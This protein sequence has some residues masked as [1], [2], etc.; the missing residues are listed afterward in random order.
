MN[1]LKMNNKSRIFNDTNSYLNKQLVAENLSE[2]V[3]Y[4]I[5]QGQE[6]APIP[7]FKI[8]TY[9]ILTDHLGSTTVITNASGGV[10]DNITYSPYGL[11][12]DKAN[13]EKRLYTGQQFD[14]LIGEYYY[15]ARYYDPETDRFV[16]P[17]TIFQDIY[18]PQNLNRYSYVL[19]NPYKL[20][21]KS[22]HVVVHFS[23]FGND[24]R[25]MQS[26][27]A[28][29][30][31]DQ[32]SA[33][34]NANEVEEASRYIIDK[35]TKDPNQPIII[36]GHS[37]GGK[38]AVDL[39]QDL[40]DMNLEVDYLFVIDKRSGRS[41]SKP[42]NVKELINI[43][44]DK[45]FL[46]GFSIE[47]QDELIEIDATHTNIDRNEKTRLIIQTTVNAKYKEYKQTGK[48]KSYIIKKSSQSGTR[49][50]NRVKHQTNKRYTKKVG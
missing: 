19:N 40:A 44:Q 4:M 43:R 20:L 1:I 28:G 12:I 5:A 13:S 42:D 45:G 49:D 29:Y 33:V 39:S 31:Q 27:R 36:V 25:D 41:D 7:T 50:Q 46:K 38:S 48:I 22:G 34:F 32:P 37:I 21:D 14:S 16:Q 3:I 9:F 26:L 18:I 6:E 35:I 23:G 17:D 15:G 2:P 8:T 11:Q 24:Q 30:I 47:G 10:L